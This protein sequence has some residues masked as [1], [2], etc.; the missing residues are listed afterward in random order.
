MKIDSLVAGI[1]EYLVREAAPKM[2]SPVTRFV[3]GA[4]ASGVGRRVMADRIA[5]LVSF[6]ADGDDVDLG[7]L[8]EAVV[9]GLEASGP[10]PLLGG[11]VT[12]DGTD[13]ASL[14]AFL[15]AEAR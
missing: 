3:L 13:A 15:K 9:S 2:A 6:V 12:V 11:L 14:F 4:A 7:A 5:P 1:G 10:V 8:E